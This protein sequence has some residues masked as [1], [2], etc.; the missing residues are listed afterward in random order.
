[1]EVKDMEGIGNCGW[2]PSI[3]EDDI[4][5]LLNSEDLI[6]GSDSYYAPAV[7]DIAEYLDRAGRLHNIQWNIIESPDA[8]YENGVASICW[9]ENGQL[10]H[11]MINIVY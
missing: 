9:V 1:M 8:A 4:Y 6:A 11:I 5:K 10:H 3:I 7:D 2:R